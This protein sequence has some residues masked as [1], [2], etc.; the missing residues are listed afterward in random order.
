M[1]SFPP[2]EQIAIPTTTEGIAIH[3]G[4][5]SKNL[6]ELNKKMDAVQQN[7]VNRE[8]WVTNGKKVDD[9][10]TRIRALEAKTDSIPLMQ[11]I[12]YGGVSLVLISV[13]SSIIYLVIKK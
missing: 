4:Y 5:I 8:E 2:T 6:S 7:T 9:H 12:I 11:K 3:L 13:L 10:E 1:E